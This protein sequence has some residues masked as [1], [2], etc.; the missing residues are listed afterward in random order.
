MAYTTIHE[1]PKSVH[2]RSLVAVNSKPVKAA[3][4]AR[5]STSDLELPGD[6]INVRD[7]LY[8]FGVWNS[9]YF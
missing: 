4:G 9:S 6:W 1:A 5:D 8:I 2:V 3:E 7:L